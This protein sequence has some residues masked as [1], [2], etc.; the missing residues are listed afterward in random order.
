MSVRVCVRGER[1]EAASQYLN[2]E[3]GIGYYTGRGQQFIQ[4]GQM[5]GKQINKKYGFD[6]GLGALAAPFAAVAAEV[7]IF[8]Y[9]GS[10]A[11]YLVKFFVKFLAGFIVGLPAVGDVLVLA[12][13]V[14][15]GVGYALYKRLR[16]K[17]WG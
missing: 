10:L 15:A 9:G 6:V 8:L 17:T 16:G 2:G 11:S 13:V 12:A 14:A 5:T 4:T 7:L 1:R 3:T